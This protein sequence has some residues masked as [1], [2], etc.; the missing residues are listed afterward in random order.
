MAIH[1]I[2]SS[3]V[4]LGLSK[5]GGTATYGTTALGTTATYMMVVKYDYS[6]SPNTASVWL[7]STNQTTEAGA[8]AP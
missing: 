1:T 2:N 7:L 3:G 6:T 8:G 4:K 5:A